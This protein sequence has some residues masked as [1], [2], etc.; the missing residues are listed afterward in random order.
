[1][2][3][4]IPLLVCACIALSVP[5]RAVH[6]PAAPERPV[7][8][9]GQSQALEDKGLEPKLLN[10]EVAGNVEALVG[11]EKAAYNTFL[12]WDTD[13][14]SM[15]DADRADPKAVDEKIAKMRAFANPEKLATLERLLESNR[16]LAARGVSAPLPG[17]SERSETTLGSGLSLSSDFSLTG[18]RAS[19]FKLGPPRLSLTPV[20]LSLSPLAPA[21]AA[22]T[23]FG[24]WLNSYYCKY[25]PEKCVR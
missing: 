19:D 6:S 2:G 9:K 17:A 22:P 20:P 7:F 18:A 13:P 25:V 12:A 1:M 14:P 11:K 3:R 4:R 10:P 21:A 5:A 23:D 16:K 8:S 15:I 24:S